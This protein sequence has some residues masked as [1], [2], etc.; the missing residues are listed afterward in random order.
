MISTGGT[1]VSAIEALL[2]KGCLPQV[3]VVASHGLLVDDAVQRF[4]SLPVQRIVLTD[5]VYQSKEVSLPIE[6]VSL[7]EMLADTIRRLHGGSF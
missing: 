4:A 1:M 3:T 2:E 7:K 6:V 5:S